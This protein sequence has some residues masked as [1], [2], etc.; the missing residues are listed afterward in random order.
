M[1]KLFSCVLA[2][3]LALSLLSV[4]GTASAGGSGRCAEKADRDDDLPDL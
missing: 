2:F 1:K 3:V 4:S